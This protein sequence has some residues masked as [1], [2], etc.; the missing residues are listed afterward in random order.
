MDAQLHV[1][2][3]IVAFVL[4]LSESNILATEFKNLKANIVKIL[5]CVKN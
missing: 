3:V 5:L 4:F 2:M 1:S